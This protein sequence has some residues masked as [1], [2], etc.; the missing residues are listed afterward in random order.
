MGR[1][2]GRPGAWRSA[3]AFLASWKP[4]MPPYHWMATTAPLT[5]CSKASAIASAS[6]RPQ[7]H[8]DPDRRRDFGFH[9]QHDRHQDMTDDDDHQI[10]REVV[11]AVVMQFLAAARAVVG[12]LQEGAAIGPRRRPDT[13]MQS[14][15]HACPALVAGVLRRRG[16]SHLQVRVHPGA[17]SSAP[18]DASAHVGRTGSRRSSTA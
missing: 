18:L 2:A 9:H 11:G 13:A 16:L 12:D 7:H 17:G 10:G 1:A 6:R 8:A 5:G 15:P 4:C 3:R 14:A